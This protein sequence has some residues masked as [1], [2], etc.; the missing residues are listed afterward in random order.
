[1]GNEAQVSTW[2]RKAGQRGLANRGC[3]S[4]MPGSVGAQCTAALRGRADAHLMLYARLQRTPTEG[5]EDSV[6][7]SPERA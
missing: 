1:M 4:S 5:V 3:C 7:V 6:E 2:R